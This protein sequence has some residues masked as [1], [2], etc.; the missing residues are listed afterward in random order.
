M[1]CFVRLLFCLAVCLTAGSG[2]RGAVDLSAVIRACEAYR[3]AE[4]VQLL[5]RSEVGVTAEG[6]RY[7][8]IALGKM[9]RWEEAVAAL[10]RAAGMAPAN[11]EVLIDL[12]AAQGNLALVS[13]P[14]GKFNGARKARAS[15]ERAVALA[16]GNL[17]A[18]SGLFAYYLNVPGIVGGDREKSLG[19]LAELERLDVVSGKLARAELALAD[20]DYARAFALYREVQQSHPGEHR[21]FYGFGRVAALSG[22]ELDAGLACLRR[23][24]ALAAPWRTPGTPGV[25]LRIGDILKRQG[26]VAGARAAYQESLRVLPEYPFA[27]KALEQLGKQ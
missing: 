23:C 19:Q 15:L 25:Y 27:R 6:L 2:L 1:R 11:V 21:A 4:A 16:P 13:G 3:F 5:E 22:R 24:L 7:R 12:A 18:R 9:G 17:D 8:G 26:D 20:K 14:L 10:E